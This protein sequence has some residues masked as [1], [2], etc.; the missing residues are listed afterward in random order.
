M[1][2]IMK[3]CR[4]GCGAGLCE[5]PA[6]NA[7]A[8]SRRSYDHRVRAIVNEGGDASLLADLEIPRS[9]LSSWMS[10]GR[11]EVVTLDVGRDESA[12]HSCVHEPSA[13][14]CVQLRHA[15][16]HEG[17]V[18]WVAARV[19]ASIPAMNAVAA[20]RRS[21]DHRVRAIVNEGGD[22]SL[23]ADLEIPRS[24]SSC[25]GNAPRDPAAESPSCA[26]TWGHDRDGAWAVFGYPNMRESALNMRE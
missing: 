10:R 4:L 23:L 6:M 12:L 15:R 18:A 17:N 2:G 19:C 13:L 5:H 21:Y 25:A 16:N 9:T 1:R 26:S 24:A 20:S 14:F 8:A 3:E 11:I 7:V 22:A